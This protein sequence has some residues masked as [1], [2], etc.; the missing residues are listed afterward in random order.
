[1]LGFVAARGS[2]SDAPAAWTDRGLG[3]FLEGDADGD[4]V[5]GIGGES[6]LLIEASHGLEWSAQ[7]HL[8]ARVESS[9]VGRDVGVVEAFVQ[10]R[11]FGTDQRWQLRVGQSFLPTS[12]ENVERLWVSPYTLTHS[13]LNSWIGEELR[14]LGVDLSWRRE[15]DNQRRLELGA[16][17]FGNNDASGALLAWRGFA[18]HDRLSYYGETLP[19]PPLASL[20]DPAIF[21]DQDDNG[22]TPFGADLDGRPGYALRARWSTEKQTWMLTAVDT[23]GDLGLHDGE[24]AWRTRF[25]LAGFEHNALAEG[26]GYAAEALGGDSR[27]GIPGLPKAHIRFYTAYLLASYGADPWRYSVRVEGFDI[28]DIDQT[29]AENNEEQGWALT[30]AAIRYAGP[31]RLGMELLYVDGRRPGAGE[32]AIPLQTGGEQLRFEARYEF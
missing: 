17:V 13:A 32:L 28:D 30:L 19:L 31:W 29:I 16:T 1:M 5:F 23:R 22:T 6:R 12:R 2:I 8:G 9:A 10:R 7:L 14:P 3:R 25:L 21:G 26:W 20:G 11:W 24:Y 18:W 15:F 27:M 4:A